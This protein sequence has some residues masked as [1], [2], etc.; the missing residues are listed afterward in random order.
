MLP[1]FR[2]F[3]LPENA[4]NVWWGWSNL[5]NFYLFIYLFWEEFYTIKWGLPLEWV[6]WSIV[7]ARQPCRS[8]LDDLGLSSISGTSTFAQYF[9]PN[10]PACLWY[11]RSLHWVLVLTFW[12]CEMMGR[13]GHIYADWMIWV[14][15][16]KLA[17][18]YSSTM[19][20]WSDCSFFCDSNRC[21]GS[22]RRGD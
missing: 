12:L 21:S 16:Q 7:K 18:I 9:F 5:S 20:V 22:S 19:Y 10:T 8:W 1:S 13:K 15:S 14:F 11:F 6:N 3:I 4:V 2:Y 17:K